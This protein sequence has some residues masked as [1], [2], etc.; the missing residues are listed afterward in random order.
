[1]EFAVSS[2]VLMLA[3]LA[4]LRYGMRPGAPTPADIVVFVFNWLF[5]DLA[6]KIQ[7]L[8]VPNTLVNTSSVVPEQVLITNLIC[9]LFIAAFT[10]VYSWL[11]RR[12]GRGGRS[13][14]QTAPA[15][16]G[17]PQPRPLPFVG[18]FL[19]VSACILVVAAGAKGLYANTDTVV[20]I[21]P[22][23]LIVHKFL[24]FL[25]SATLMI[26]LHETVI[27]P[28]KVQFS[29]VC[30]LMLLL[31]LVAATENP[32]TEKRNGL[33][34]IYLGLIF[35]AF[36]PSLRS[37]NRRLLLLIASMVLVFPAITVLTHNHSQVFTGVKLSAVLDTLKDHYFSTHYDAWA[38]IYTTVE[39]VRRQGVLWGHQLMGAFFFWVPSSMWH[40]KPL[41]S[42]IAIANYLIRNYSMWFTNLSAPLIA[43][44]YLDFG[45]AGVAVYGAAL[46]AVV[47]LMNRAEVREGR[48]FLFPFATYSALFLM[49]ALRGSLMIAFAYGTGAL[50]AFLMASGLLSVGQRH[51]GERYFLREIPPRF[52]MRGSSL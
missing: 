18:V 46:A 17:E 47:K 2:V 40:G 19:T 15:P 27:S 36:E 44:A 38:N 22:S 16:P 41:A 33:G 42:G 49:F 20:V 24:L 25:P 51:L 28:R 13:A 23:D 4:Q 45:A 1:V 39:M 12:S 52:E 6:P 9:A 50:L 10:V 37:L 3:L 21:T 14:R 32:L 7:L 29:R 43:E 5:L 34:P 48:W 35:I 8:S 30:V 26:L 31:L 11:N